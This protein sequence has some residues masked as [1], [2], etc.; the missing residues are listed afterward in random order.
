MKV[1]LDKKSLQQL[2][3]LLNSTQKAAEPTFGQFVRAV[4]ARSMKQL[5]T[6]ADLAAFKS[7]TSGTT[8]GS[9][10]VPE[11]QAN[12]IVSLLSTGGVLRKS[13]AKLLPCGSVRKFDIPVETGAINIQYISENSAGTSGADDPSFAQR[14]HVTKDMRALF[15]AH[16][17]LART[18]VP[19]FDMV[20][21]D[22]AAKSVARAEDYSFFR[23]MANGPT[24]LPSMVGT[25]VVNQAG[26]AL[27]YTDLTAMVQAAIDVEAPVEDCAFYVNG[28]TWNKI[29]SIKDSNGRPILKPCR[30]ENGSAFEL[31]GFPLYITPTIP[32]HIGSGAATSYILFTYPQ[33]VQI[34]DGAMELAISSHF[35]FEFDQVA[36]RVI[37]SVDFSLGQP[38][39]AIILEGVI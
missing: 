39:A 8:P 29:Y 21:R 22:L 36:V 38:S 13:G 15:Y 19:V 4:A 25:T 32:N 12:E 9:V 31:L 6:A 26:A 35:K 11:I 7:L 23:G 30:G 18:S 28:E 3:S 5:G 20:V 24:A 27:A 2:A 16:N 1:S 37:K 14:T 17:N 33:N 10:L 34:A